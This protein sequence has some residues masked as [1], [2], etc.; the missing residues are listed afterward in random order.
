MLVIF[1]PRVIEIH[2]FRFFMKNLVLFVVI[3]SLGKLL[4]N[5]DGQK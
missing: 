5:L 2:L 1:I 4:L 3:I